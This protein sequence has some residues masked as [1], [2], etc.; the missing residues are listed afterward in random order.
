MQPR[1][2]IMNKHMNIS[3]KWKVRISDCNILKAFEKKEKSFQGCQIGGY[4]FKVGST[5]VQTKIQKKKKNLSLLWCM[6]GLQ[7]ILKSNFGLIW[8]PIMPLLHHPHCTHHFL[9]M[10]QCLYLDWLCNN[11]CNLNLEEKNSS[12]I[13]LFLPTHKYS[14]IWCRCIYFF[15]EKSNS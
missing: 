14:E 1:A 5:Q 15:H 4:Q 2:K 9:Q 11:I 3:L 8:I 10:G 12:I 13:F 7:I 6:K